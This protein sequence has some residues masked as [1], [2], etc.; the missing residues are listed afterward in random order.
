MSQLQIWFE[1]IKREVTEGQP[2]ARRV[3]LM[4]GDVGTIWETWENIS[5]IDSAQWAID[6]EALIA[7][8]VQELP[9]KRVQLVFS[10]EDATGAQVS[11]LPRTVMGQNV[12]A[13]D[14]GTQNG[15][16]ALADAMT[17][18]GK[19]METTL[20]Q[21]RGMLEFQAQQLEKAQENIN[22]AHEFFMAIREAERTHTEQ[23]GVASKVMMEQVQQATPMLMAMVQHWFNSK[24]Q[25]LGSAIGAASAASNGAKVS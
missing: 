25:G 9:K 22:D 23:E 10:A 12:N 21:A 11:N 7:A 2:L 20:A 3:R 4:T 15:A 6:G 14:L 19:L 13:Q 5:D 16:K 24:Q 8:L 1:K 18:I 17:S